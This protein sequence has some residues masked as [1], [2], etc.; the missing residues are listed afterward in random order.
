MVERRLQT[1]FEICARLATRHGLTS[2]RQ[3]ISQHL[4]ALDAPD[5]QDVVQL[6]LEPDQH[7][8][9]RAAKRPWSP[10]ASRDLLLRHRPDHGVRAAARQLKAP[11]C[12]N[13]PSESGHSSVQQTLFDCLSRS[14]L[15]ASPRKS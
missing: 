10:T 14:L 2:T 11:D 1:L 9:V 13:Q 5:D 12:L 15:V 3:A 6:L 8:A 4:D 7:L